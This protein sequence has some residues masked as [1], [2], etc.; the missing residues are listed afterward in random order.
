MDLRHLLES[1]LPPK[2]WEFLRMVGQEAEACRCGAFLVGGAVRDLH[3]GRPVEDLDIAIEGDAKAIVDSIASRGDGRVVGHPHFGTATISWQGFQ[4]DFVT[5]R[6]EHYARPGA[7]PQVRPGTV[8]DDLRR[9]DFT[10]NAM[11]VELTFPRLGQLLDP[12]QGRRDLDQRIVRV[13]HQGSFEEDATRILRAIRYEQRLGFRLERH[14]EAFLR[15]DLQFLRTI[16]GDRLRKELERIL[17]EE[18]PELALQRA[19]ELGALSV[20]GPGLQADLW[21]V[22]RYECLRVD[23]GSRPRRELYWGLLCFR[24]SEEQ[25]RALVQHLHLPRV[26]AN[27]AMEVL[28][29]RASLSLLGRAHLSPSSL[30]H[31][32]EKYHLS[33]LQAFATGVEDRRVVERVKHYLSQLRFI[34]PTLESRELLMLGVPEGPWLGQA[35]NTLR[36]LRL[37]GQIHS[38]E[39]AKA[40]V[41]QWLSELRTREGNPQ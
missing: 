31:R 6:T 21:L 9:R 2:L 4:V 38:K 12:F 26:V 19:A 17:A 1:Q 35:L 3:L 8:H 5:A 32:L 39:E 16:S 10:I 18:R 20:V 29:L 40:W 30:Y 28:E 37:D 23:A 27:V 22:E 41:Q 33:S 24:L 14:T 34:R 36:D 15:R 7:L 13:L 25:V 11:A